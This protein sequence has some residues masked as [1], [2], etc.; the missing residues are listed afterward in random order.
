MVVLDGWVRPGDA[1]LIM[2]VAG[3]VIVPA[4]MVVSIAKTVRVLTG[5]ARQMEEAARVTKDHVLDLG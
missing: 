1:V 3:E 2:P 4:G 5:L